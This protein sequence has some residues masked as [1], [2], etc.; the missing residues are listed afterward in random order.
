M[1]STLTSKPPLQNTAAILG[2]AAKIWLDPDN[3]WRRQ[4]VEAM[5][6]ST[7]Y[8]RL[9]IESALRSA[10]EEL[11]EE[12]LSAF[13]ATEPGFQSAR[14]PERVL[15][16][17]A[18]NVFT[19]WL[20]GAV[21]T[22]L[23]DARCDLKPSSHEP[24]FASLWKRSIQDIDVRL[25][26]QIQVVRWSDTLLQNY[27]AIVAYGSD[28]SLASL[29]SQ[30]P[31]EVR[32]IE[33]GH[34]LSVAIFWKEALV[35]VEL[36][37]WMDK[38]EKDVSAFDLQGCLSPQMLYLEAEDPGMFEELFT[39]VRVMPKLKLFES[40]TELKRELEGYRPHL[41]TLGFAGPAS[42]TQEHE[43]E[44]KEL[45]LSRI[46]PIGEMQQPPLSWRN[47]GISLVEELCAPVSTHGHPRRS[48]A[49]DP[50]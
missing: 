34:K 24:L 15:H 50:S 23:L 7:G 47:G 10:F 49:E 29:K 21:T 20:P 25:G 14:G 36:A 43:A 8:T 42:R 38:L 35:P 48:S 31:G 37:R 28:H 44:W 32:F 5:Q 12:K 26:E 9:M 13:C 39:R 46:C 6:V 2:R 3:A 40:W 30:I 27:P 16:I 19:S 41:S 1:S 11:T 45:G 17:L 22:L 33:Y 18:G 4:A